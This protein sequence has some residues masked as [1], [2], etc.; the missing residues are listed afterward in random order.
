L[1][2]QLKE[3]G[4]KG[5]QKELTQAIGKAM[6][7]V[8]AAI[9]E[10]ARDTLPERGGLGE[11]VARSRISQ[12]RNKNGLRLVASGGRR[13][14]LDKGSLRHPVF[15]NPDKWVDQRVKPGWWSRPVKAAEDDV[16]REIEQAMQDVVRKLNR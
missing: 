13:D 7:P 3:L 4:D 12:R 8:K 6:K 15:G 11:R 14:L 5:L 9:R 10:S 1:S 2:R 16:R